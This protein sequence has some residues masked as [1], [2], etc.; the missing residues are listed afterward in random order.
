MQ[1]PIGAVG[2]DMNI[3]SAV[4]SG[5]TLAVALRLVYQAGKLVR[6]LE[7]HDRRI[8]KIEDHIA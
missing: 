5:S 1:T 6:T 7:D 2:V 4:F 3:L 8:E